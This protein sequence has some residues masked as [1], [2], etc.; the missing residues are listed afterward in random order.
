MRLSSTG[1]ASRPWSLPIW[2][3]GWLFDEGEGEEA[4]VGGVEEAEAVEARLD[5]EEG[6][7]FAVDEDA[8]GAELGDPGV[9]GVAG[10]VVE[11]LAVGGEVA[12][13]EDEGDFVFAGGQVERVFDLV[14]EEEHAEEAGV[15]VEAVDAHGVVV[16]PEGGGVLLEGVVAGAGL[17]RGRTSLRGSRRLWRRTWRRGGGRWCGRRGC[18]GRSR[19]GSG[20]WGGSV[21]WGDC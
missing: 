7:D 12:V 10:D 3:K 15:G 8:V 21:W 11:E 16:V 5:L 19:G 1:A 2:R 6:A 17:G 14:A 18:R 4:A 9:F 20:R 13:V